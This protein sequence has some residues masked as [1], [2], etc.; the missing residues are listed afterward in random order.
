MWHRSSCLEADDDL[1]CAYQGCFQVEQD[2]DRD[3]G[4]LVAH[5]SSFVTVSDCLI[6][7]RSRGYQYG[8]ITK[9]RSTNDNNNGCVPA[10]AA[11]RCQC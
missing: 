3:E 11:M 10:A 4:P 9:Q 6:E 7:C 5:G 1:L 2:F 8:G